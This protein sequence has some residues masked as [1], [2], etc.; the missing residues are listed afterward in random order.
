MGS[1]WISD[2]I[3]WE[4]YL[5]PFLFKRLPPG[6]GWWATLGSLCLLLFVLLVTTGIILAMYYNPSPYKA[7]QSVDYIMNEVPMGSILRGLHHWGGGAMVLVVFLH[8]MTTF[9]AGSYKAPREL[10]WIIGVFLF[11][12]TLGLGFTGYLLPWD[13]KAYWATV[14][15]SSIVKSVPGIGSYIARIMLAG[16]SLSGLTLT[17]F[18]AIHTLLLP[19]L[20]FGLAV[21]HIYLV[22]IHGLAES[23][24]NKPC[25]DEAGA[26]VQRF[27]PEH[28]FRSSIVFLAVLLT[29]IGLAVLGTVPR[30]EVA[31]TIIDSYQPRPEWYYMW[32]FQLLTYFS[33]VWE[34]IFSLAIPVVGIALLLALPFLGNPDIRKVTDRPVSVAAGAT[35]VICLVYL[36]YMGFA[37]ARP[38]G[39]TIPVP[40]RTMAAHE[41]RVLFIYVDRECSYCHQIS[42]RGGNRIGP[43]LANIKPKGRTADYLSKYVQN[44][45]A[46]RST[47]F[48]PKY[49]MPERDL[50]A[51][52][53]FMLALDFAAYPMQIIKREEVLKSP[54]AP[55][56]HS[57][58]TSK[59]SDPVLLN[60]K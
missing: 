41:Q 37:S 57:V 34:T 12:V 51:L 50:S 59:T 56:A 7:Y 42:G 14:V 29:L 1:N 2:R 39:Q 38:Y 52:A 9:F 27:F 45:Q 58:Q 36:T 49:E 3:G 35:A 21:I 32:L 43:D 60:H 46:I 44:P 40:Q 26:P 8:L 16:E 17:R 24:E 23:T 48:M 5:K 4:P 15:S 18:Y 25:E 53:A 22:R 19:P 13:M 6:T 31:G 54:S 33:G 20:L 10:T 28:L 30:E 47:S 55:Q 11:L